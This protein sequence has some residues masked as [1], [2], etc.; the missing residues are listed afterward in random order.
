M[1]VPVPISNTS[2]IEFEIRYGI[3]CARKKS[4]QVPCYILEDFSILV[5]S[6]IPRG[7]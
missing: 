3:I 7:E 2:Y 6:I 5:L 4:D 1:P